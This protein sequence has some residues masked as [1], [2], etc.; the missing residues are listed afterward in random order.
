MT[1]KLKDIPRAAEI[2][3]NDTEAVYA[4]SQLLARL[5]EWHGGLNMPR[6][7]SA[8]VRALDAEGEYWLTATK[9]LLTDGPLA[10]IPDL[11]EA[12][13]FIH[14]VCRGWDDTAFYKEVRVDAM[15]RW[16]SGD[17][18]LT[19]TQIVCLLRPI[20]NTDPR[21]ATYCSAC[22]ASW[23]KEL[24]TY[25]RFN[26]ITT[27]EAYQR[28]TYILNHNLLAFGADRTQKL[29]W[30]TPYLTDDI[31]ALTT[32]ALQAYIPFA[33]TLSALSRTPFEDTEAETETL[34]AELALRP[35]LHHL[36]RAAIRLGLDTRKRLLA[37]N[38]A[39]ETA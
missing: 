38:Y 1:T 9:R 7:N 34:S 20:A 3:Y 37:L 28:L 31:A 6:E 4:Y 13:T 30:A 24:R 11:L 17:K 35:D 21:Y 12:Y 16:L 36:H 25:G 19:E 5:L 2:D 15:Q 14:R 22:L 18:T 32:P 23:V 29:T 33:R 27:A 39:E 10:A 8:T 26:G